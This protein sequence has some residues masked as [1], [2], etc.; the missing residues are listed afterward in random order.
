MQTERGLLLF[1][2]PKFINFSVMAFTDRFIK[3]PIKVFSV[4][5]K[6]LTGKEVCT[7]VWFKFNPFEIQSYRPCTND[8]YAED[9]EAIV[10]VLKTGDTTVVYLTPDEFE[11]LLNDSAK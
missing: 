5:Q 10:L 2:P 3:V 7:D 9:G 8:D 1:I 6:E 11:T 4:T